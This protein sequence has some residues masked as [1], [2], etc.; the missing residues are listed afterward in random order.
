[1]SQRKS[2]HRPAVSVTVQTLA[3][4]ER[5]RRSWPRLALVAGTLFCLVVGLATLAFWYTVITSELLIVDDSELYFI[6][7]IGLIG[8]MIGALGLFIAIGT[9][10][11]AAL[12][13]ADLLEAMERAASGD[14]DIQ[15]QERG[16]REIR[17][18]T[19]AFND[20]LRRE[21]AR[22]QALHTLTAQVAHELQAR[23]S[24]AGTPSRDTDVIR[25][26]HDWYTW[27]LLEN[28]ALVLQR[29]TL[30]M[31]DYVRELLTSLHPQASGCGV[32]LR[33]EIADPAPVAKIDRL[34][35]GQALQCLVVNALARSASGG[36]IEIDLVEE[37]KPHLLQVAVT[38]H[39][40]TLTPAELDRLF[41]QLGPAT[42]LGSGLELP[43][44]ARLV[45][46]HG[47]RSAAQSDA[48]KGTTV[49]FV[50]PL[51]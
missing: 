31:G 26:V 13:T 12:P 29:E 38:D 25:L 49:A 2:A 17:T 40:R 10:R 39:G 41:M 1:M 9:F 34:R 20:F 30:N 21:Q 16:P 4:R 32:A 42:A 47:G 11:R 8:L 7:N 50:L 33:A 27:T 45:A 37:R 46:A 51:D 43:L 36:E 19:R 5:P 18:L 44:A 35:L 48:E 15:V 24:P 23:W 14:L 28:N 3:P 22:D 6:R